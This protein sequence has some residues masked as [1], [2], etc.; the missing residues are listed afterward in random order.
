MTK[1]MNEQE[2]LSLLKSS[3]TFINEIPNKMVKI[4][5]FRTSYQLA[6]ALTDFINKNEKVII[7]NTINSTTDDS[8][9]DKGA[10]IQEY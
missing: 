3:L 2:A 1:R 4:G 6:S 7:V 5:T 9:K 8:R 10:T